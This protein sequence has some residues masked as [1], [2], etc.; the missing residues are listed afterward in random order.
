MKE[1]LPRD[2]FIR[3]LRHEKVDRVPVLYRMKLE[4]KEKLLWHSRR[5]V[6][7]SNV[8][9][10]SGVGPTVRAGPPPLHLLRSRQGCI[11][12][13]RT[14]VRLI[15]ACCELGDFYSRLRLRLGRSQRCSTS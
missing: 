15:E 7:V 12:R 2:R 4:A 14:L 6:D 10:R 13:G 11:R 1:L 8:A 5:G 9:N 3:T